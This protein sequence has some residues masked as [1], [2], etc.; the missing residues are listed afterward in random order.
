[1]DTTIDS[2]IRIKNGYMSK[3][4]SVLITN[5][6]VTVQI[7]KIL[8]NHNYI[9]EFT[10]V[11][12]D[13]HKIKVDLVYKDNKPAVNQLIINSKPGRRIYQQAKDIKPV[14]GGMGLSVLSTSSGLLSDKDARKVKLGG[15]LLFSIW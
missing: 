9:G 11:A 2:L 3:K 12:G 15:E 13:K 10:P 8:K 7:C 5:T 14:L 4:D 6:K 1:M